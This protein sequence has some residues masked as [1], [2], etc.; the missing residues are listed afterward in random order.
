MLRVSTVRK[1]LAYLMVFYFFFYPQMLTAVS[2]K[3][4]YVFLGAA[5]L[6]ALLCFMS[7]NRQKRIDIYQFEWLIIL[8]ISSLRNV[9]LQHRDYLW[10]LTFIA[11]ILTLL[12]LGQDD[13]WCDKLLRTACL[14][15]TV[16]I[17][18][19]F[20]FY[21]IPS[22]YSSMISFWGYIPNGT[23]LG[24]FGY[25]AG[26]ADNHSANGTY[27]VVPFLIGT[28]VL[29][30][31]TI[32]KK[33]RKKWYLL[34]GLSAVA[35]FLTT[36]RAHLVFGLAATLIT[37]YIFSPKRM[38]RKLFR[39]LAIMVTALV[40]LQFVQNTPYFSEILGGFSDQGIDIS[41][42]RFE[43]WLYAISIFMANPLLGIGWLGFRYNS[44]ILIRGTNTGGI[45]YV[46]AHNVYVQ[47]LC[48]TG[49]LGAVFI[50]AVFLHFI[51]STI[52]FYLKEKEKLTLVQTRVLAA[53]FALQFFCLI[54]GV[55]GNFL[56]DRTCFIYVFGCALFCAVKKSIVE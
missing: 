30:S 6:F 23:E 22:I 14:F 16:Y 45:G 37:Y 43:Y 15:S 8:A 47:L 9:G 27:C 39:L 25:R 12:V 21:M 2:G 56:Y 3:F 35:V 7:G 19:C 24:R 13:G 10:P 26:L 20:V 34:V 49:I 1:W 42:G 50:I 32:Q 41:N 53:S 31:G 44:S 55:T 46:D 51:I 40:I 4:L 29:L 54:Y 52:R 38:N 36:K 5:I 11:L 18:A 28:S 17:I 48:E 33:E